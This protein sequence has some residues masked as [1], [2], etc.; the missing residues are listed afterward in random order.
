MG[1]KAVGTGVISPVLGEVREF[2]WRCDKPR[3]KSVAV[4][5][6]NVAP[7]GWRYHV[8][9][10]SEYSSWDA[11]WCKEC[12][13]AFERSL[14]KAKTAMR[15]S[16]AKRRKEKEINDAKRLLEENHYRVVVP[17]PSDVQ[18]LE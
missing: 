11:I 5:E 14:K 6:K 16:A 12:D 15:I 17:N 2:H 7:D 9:Y 3:C 8:I 18:A 13:E 1:V 10:G 4:T